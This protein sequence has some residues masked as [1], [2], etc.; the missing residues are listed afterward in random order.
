MW[1]DE[2]F[3]KLRRAGIGGPF[4]NIVKDMYKNVSGRIKY[5]NENI[6]ASFPIKQ[7]VKQ[8]DVL[9]PML[10]NIYINDIIALF[11]EADSAPPKVIDSTVG[12]LLYADDLVI[13]SITDEGLQNSLNK[14]FL[15]QIALGSK[16]LKV[17]RNVLL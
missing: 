12:C 16:P 17:K 11:Q 8:G 6:S 1:H 15:H 2:L 3:L 5:R 9:S 7:G 10:F 4:Y 13:L 14:I